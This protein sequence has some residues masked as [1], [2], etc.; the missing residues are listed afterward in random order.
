MQFSYPGL[1]GKISKLPKM[2]LTALSRGAAGLDLSI[3]DI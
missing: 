3:W 2:L 1:S